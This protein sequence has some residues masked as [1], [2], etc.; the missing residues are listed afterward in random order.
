MS[1]P[2][3]TFT[4]GVLAR[5]AGV[6]LETVRYY[7]R[8]GLLQQPPRNSAGYRL[9]PAEAAGRLRFIRRAQQLGFSL[10]EIR[11]LLSLRASSTAKSMDVRKRVEAK[12]SAVDAKIRNLRSLK[13]DLRKLMNICESRAPVSQCQILRNL[14][15]Q[16]DT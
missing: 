10:S 9:F 3:K 8:L 5:E 7:E 1:K 16:S 12:M 15:G 14:E 2:A 13:K 4:I 11:E 6:G